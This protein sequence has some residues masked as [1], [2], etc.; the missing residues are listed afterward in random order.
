MMHSF[1][2]EARRDAGEQAVRLLR[3]MVV[4][5]VVPDPEDKAEAEN[6]IRYYDSAEGGVYP[7]DW[8][9]MNRKPVR[10]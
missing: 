3:E 10:S 7:P 5:G 1:E 8:R 9:R 2:D 4:R 6:L